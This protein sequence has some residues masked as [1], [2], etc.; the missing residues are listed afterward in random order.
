MRKYRLLRCCYDS[1]DSHYGT[2]GALEVQ[3]ESSSQAC[4][5]QQE[6]IGISHILQQTVPHECARRLLTNYNYYCL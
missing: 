3:S 6:V 2:Q 5:G 1:G 4:Q